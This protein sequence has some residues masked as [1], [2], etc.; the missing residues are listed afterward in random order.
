MMYLWENQAINSM[1]QKVETK[2][3]IQK[4]VIDERA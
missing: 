3:S 4:K 1:K 2:V